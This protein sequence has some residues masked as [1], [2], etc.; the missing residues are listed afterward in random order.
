MIDKGKGSRRNKP[1]EQS[2][3]KEGHWLNL[4]TTNSESY[5][6]IRDKV[7]FSLGRVSAS[8]DHSLYISIFGTTLPSQDALPLHL[9]L[10][11]QFTLPPFQAKLS[12]SLLFTFWQQ[13]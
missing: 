2:R 7:S 10:G 13:T 12:M 4:I 11:V 9:L 3:R 8:L 1:K 5:Q 6:A